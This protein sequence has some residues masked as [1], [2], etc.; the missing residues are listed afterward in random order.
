MNHLIYRIDP[1]KDVVKLIVD[2]L[3]LPVK[4]YRLQCNDV[5]NGTEFDRQ[6]RRLYLMGKKWP[7]VF[8][9]T[10]TDGLLELTN[11]K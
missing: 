11:W 10:I 2:A 5:L 3:A 6:T 9:V 1:Q 4:G 8:E 7:V